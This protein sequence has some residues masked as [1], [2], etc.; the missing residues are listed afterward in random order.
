MAAELFIGL[1]ARMREAQKNFY[2]LR[3]PMALANAR[4]FEREVDEWLAER[5]IDE[6][7]AEARE[8]NP[9][10]FPDT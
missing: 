9:G 7:R 5:E 2:R 6:I 3:N 8:R 1:A 4:R 10:L